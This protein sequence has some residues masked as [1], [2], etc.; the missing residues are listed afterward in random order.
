MKLKEL[1]KHTSNMFQVRVQEWFD[2]IATDRPRELETKLPTGRLEQSVG[3]IANI[4][5]ERGQVVICVSL[6][7]KEGEDE[8]EVTSDDCPF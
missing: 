6:V 3:L 4:V 2:D 7:P 8:E 5:L 1:L